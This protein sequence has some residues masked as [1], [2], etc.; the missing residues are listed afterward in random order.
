MVRLFGLGLVVSLAFPAFAVSPYKR[1]LAV[2]KNAYTT[3][4]VFIGGKSGKGSS[5]LGVRRTHSR[6]AKIER[7]IVDLG[8]ENL[9]N[10]G[11][12]MPFFQVS[13]D[14]ATNRVILDLAQMRMSKVTEAQLRNM[15]AKSPY[16]KDA[17]LTFDPE[18]KAATMVLSLRQPMRLEVFQLVN[19]KKPARVVMDLIPLAPVAAPKKA[20]G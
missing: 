8:D 19:K 18:D 11:K 2:K 7:V 20:R 15:F 4:G 10:A 9:R 5:I 6:K 16:V 3:D 12:S 14:K 17:S 1:T 13:M